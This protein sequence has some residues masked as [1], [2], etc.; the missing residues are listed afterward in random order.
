MSV[1][2][3]SKRRKKTDA[4][5]REESQ[6]HL[7]ELIAERASFYRANPH[8]FAKD[9]LN[10]D[11]HIFQQIIIFMMSISTNAMFLACRGGK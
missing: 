5:L 11:L 10:L 3:T 4:E 2:Q 1:Q 6:R 8:R 7:M 9:Y